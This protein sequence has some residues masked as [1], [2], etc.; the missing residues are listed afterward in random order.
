MAASG[1]A[2]QDGHELDP[3]QSRIVKQNLVGD[4]VMLVNNGVGEE[5]VRVGASGS[6][7]QTV[8]AGTQ[9]NVRLNPVTQDGALAKRIHEVG[10]RFSSEA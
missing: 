4:H 9:F 6:H 5:I 7:R 8:S 1:L 10:G 2:W 3:P